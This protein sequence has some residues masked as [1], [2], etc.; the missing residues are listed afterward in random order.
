M[1]ILVNLAKRFHDTRY[2][3]KPKTAEPKALPYV[4]LTF[5]HKE[6]VVSAAEVQFTVNLLHFYC[7]LTVNICGVRG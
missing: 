4:L 1:Q 3:Y 7:A 5:E 6:A 2:F